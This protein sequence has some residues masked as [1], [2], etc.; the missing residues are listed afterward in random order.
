MGLAPVR[1]DVVESAQQFALW[2][3]VTAVKKI[4]KTYI[5]TFVWLHSQSDFENVKSSNFKA[6]TLVRNLMAHLNNEL[7]Q[8]SQIR[9]GPY[10]NAF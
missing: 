10:Y 8:I 3:E 4:F 2:L 6:G 5:C 1:Y 9:D 7:F